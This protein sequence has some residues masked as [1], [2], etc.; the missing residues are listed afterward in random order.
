MTV[1]RFG[2]RT[3]VNDNESATWYKR[4]IRVAEHLLRI[5]EFVIRVTDEQCVDR[6]VWQVRIVFFSHDNMNVVLSSQQGPG[7]QEEER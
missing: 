3:S 7:P 6:A 5:A 2:M 1:F 4:A